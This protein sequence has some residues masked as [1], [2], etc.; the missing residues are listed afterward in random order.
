M[1]KTNIDKRKKI[2]LTVLCGCL[3]F[4][5]LMFNNNFKVSAAQTYIY[6]NKTFYN[7]TQLTEFL[8]QKQLSNENIIYIGEEYECRGAGCF[9]TKYVIIYK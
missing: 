6:K 2:I 9:I 1:E 5:F 4:V 8:N 3:L 7:T